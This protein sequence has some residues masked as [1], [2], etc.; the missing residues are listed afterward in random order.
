MVDLVP[1]PDDFRQG[2]PGKDHALYYYRPWKTLL[3][4]T[5]QEGGES[6]YFRGDLGAVVPTLWARLT[7]G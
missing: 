3:V 1:L 2:P 7:S 5:V 6:Y 4:R